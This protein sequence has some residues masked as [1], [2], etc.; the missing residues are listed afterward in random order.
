MIPCYYGS[1]AK[2]ADFLYPSG[3]RI[4]AEPQDMI[5]FIKNVFLP[6]IQETRKE[7]NA[8]RT[9]LATTNTKLRGYDDLVATVNEL[10]GDVDEIPQLRKDVDENS[11]AII[12]MQTQTDYK[13][14]IQESRRA[15]VALWV[16]AIGVAAD[17]ITRLPWHLI[18]LG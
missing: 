9:E 18:K 3:V 17:L 2:D 15:R 10:K 7:N 14:A 4:L 12:V 5:E 16:A 8:L 11:K 13:K 1:R 6:E